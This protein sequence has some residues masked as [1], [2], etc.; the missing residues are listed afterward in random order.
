MVIEHQRGA[1]E[2]NEHRD[3][4]VHETSLVKC[5]VR[6]CFIKVIDDLAGNL[7]G[8]GEFF[9]FR[10]RQFELRQIRLPK[11]QKGGMFA[12]MHALSLNNGRSVEYC[13]SISCC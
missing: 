10:A 7:C 6:A 8:H 2:I 1:G 3:K 13:P 12:R 11:D 4:R 9:L 5:N